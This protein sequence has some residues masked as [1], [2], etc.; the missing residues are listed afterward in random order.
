MTEKPTI[1]LHP[2]FREASADARDPLVRLLAAIRERDPQRV[3]DIL[4]EHPGTVNA[5]IP[6]RPG[7]KKGDAVIPG[8]HGW[9]PLHYAAQVCALQGDEPEERS[10][11]VLK[12]LIAYMADPTQITDDPKPLQPWDILGHRHALY[13]TLKDVAS[14]YQDYKLS[15]ASA[16]SHAMPVTRMQPRVKR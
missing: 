5:A 13:S 12:V 15:A 3:E 6:D 14:L 4:D 1:S 8:S 7:E 2:C 11:R 10:A 16:L 9:R